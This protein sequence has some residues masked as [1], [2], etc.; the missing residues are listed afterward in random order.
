MFDSVDVRMREQF[1]L[2]FLIIF[3]FIISD[4]KDFFGFGMHPV[5]LLFIA[6]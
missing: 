3:F 1:I 5:L 2:K 6:T 4:E